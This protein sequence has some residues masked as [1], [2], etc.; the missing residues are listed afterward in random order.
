MALDTTGKRIAHLRAKA[1]LTQEEVA[2]KAGMS[3]SAYN[4]YEKD[5]IHRFTR[6]VLERLAVALDSTPEYI[7]GINDEDINLET[8][9]AHFPDFIQKFL[10]SP[11]SSHY[12]KKAYL[13]YQ[14]DMVNGT[15][16][17]D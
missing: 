6:A 7:L 13:E 9:L 17:R 12:V 16:K 5:Q 2:G 3:Q 15:I 4:R 14:T 8:H 10:L 11:D 1:Q